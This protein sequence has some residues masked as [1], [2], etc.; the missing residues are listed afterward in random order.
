MSFDVKEQLRSIASGGAYPST[1]FRSLCKE[2]VARIAELERECD[3][4]R[5]RLC[6]YEGCQARTPQG[7]ANDACC[8]EGADDG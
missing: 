5:A 1:H 2:A 6:D 7:C 3:P 8:A 4:L